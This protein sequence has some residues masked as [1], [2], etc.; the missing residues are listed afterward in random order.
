VCCVPE[1]SSVCGRVRP[2]WNADAGPH[3]PSSSRQHPDATETP[4]DQ[5]T[6]SAPSLWTLQG[7][8]MSCHQSHTD[9]FR[10]SLIGLL[11]QSPLD[12]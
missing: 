12:Q 3:V 4:A 7:R 5:Y 6:S 8:A 10:F 11:I 1:W 9:T 2:A